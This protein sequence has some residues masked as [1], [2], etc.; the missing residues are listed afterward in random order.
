MGRKKKP[1]NNYFHEGI[2]QAILE[3]NLAKT[4]DEKDRLFRTIYPAIAKVAQV[5]YNKIKPTYVDGEPMNIQMDCISYLTERLHRIKEGKGKAFSYMT[6]C[7]RNY[8]IQQNMFAYTKVGKVL[9][10]SELPETFDLKADD[11]D[12]STEMEESAR[13]LNEF[14]DYLDRNLENLSW[15]TSRKSRPVIRAV[16]D[17]IRNIDNVENFNR[18][19][20]MNNLTNINGLSVERHYITKVFNKIE[21]HYD[22]FKKDWLKGN[23]LKYYHN[24]GLTEEEIEFCISN[25]IPGNRE[26]G[27]IGL[28]KRFGV[29]E[30]DV[31]VILNKVGLACL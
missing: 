22:L 1:E 13:L 31:R 7:A 6:V 21:T 19:D 29:N 11:F 9:N 24:D 25:Y 27:V 20:I 8:Y 14:C 2:E 12:R 30:Y 16:I 10:T 4:Q 5:F 18:R 26:L 17:L 23:P 3:Y 15:G 28:A